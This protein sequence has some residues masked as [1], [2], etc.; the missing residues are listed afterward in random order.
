[1]AQGSPV[2][3]NSRYDESYFHISSY[4]IEWL[5][6]ALA[7]IAKVSYHRDTLK[8]DSHDR[9]SNQRHAKWCD[10]LPGSALCIRFVTLR[11]IGVSFGGGDGAEKAISWD[12]MIG[13]CS[14]I[15]STL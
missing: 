14:S 1:M 7:K 11:T 3:S 2:P 15:L 13:S 6:H 4:F 10:K 8:R 5:Q 9:R 12:V